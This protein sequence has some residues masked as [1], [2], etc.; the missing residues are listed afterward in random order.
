MATLKNIIEMPQASPQR[1]YKDLQISNYDTVKDATI[2]T[3]ALKRAQ[4]RFSDKE[5]ILRAIMGYDYDFLR[6]V[7]N[8][9]SVASGIYQRLCKYLANMY[10][11]DWYIT[12]YFPE[13][14]NPKAIEMMA[15][16]RELT[17]EEQKNVDKFFEALDYMDN[18][19]VKKK[20]QDITLKVIKNGVYYGYL[21]DAKDRMMIQELPI[22]YCRSRFD[23]LGKPTVEFNLQYFDSEFKDEEARKQVFKLF[24]EE[25]KKAYDRWKKGKVEPIFEQ[26]SECWHLLDVDRAFK[27][28]G[29]GGAGDIPMLIAVIPALLE[30]EDTQDLAAKK[31]Q[32]E[33]VKL[34]IQKLPLDKNDEMVFDPDEA[35]EIH[36]NAVR[37]VANAIGVDV[38][39]TFAEVAV[40]S[41]SDTGQSSVA[42]T[43]LD[44]AKNNVF[45]E[46]GVSQ[47][48]FNSENSISLEKSILNDEASLY[49]MV[50][51]LERLLND[52][53]DLKFN[54]RKKCWFKVQILSTTIYNYKEMSKLYK[55]QTQLGFSKMLPQ[56][57][58]GQSQ[59]SILAN[60]KFENEMLQL[61][62]LFIPPL[63]SST[64]SGDFLNN[65]TEGTGKGS[66]KSVG[67][68]GSA[69]I[70]TEEKGKAGRPTNES[71]GKPTTEKTAANKEAQ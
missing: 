15:G 11:F 17:K 10:R 23:H 53:M 71:Q 2:P 1:T 54:N 33:L 29:G 45:D 6:Q 7:S 63:M 49:N 37:M 4:P 57:A 13:H 60:V 50:L 62:D 3:S 70:P 30:L 66:S 24:P 18:F 55:E 39:T 42:K 67:G 38:L 46:A 43:V 28:N 21:V 31:L 56:V 35:R 5:Q 25:F 61:W 36:N 58:L 16:N 41:L 12:P 52:I 20:F 26:G 19:E 40:E 69:E 22:K 44:S 59:S 34:V 64:M 8:F 68:G 32:Q 27:I 48:Q 14:K 51:Q 47:M 9:F 65:R